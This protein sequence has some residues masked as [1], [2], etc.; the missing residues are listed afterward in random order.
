MEPAER[1]KVRVL[2]EEAEKAAAR[3]RE[4]IDE[5]VRAGID[6]SEQERAQTELEASIARMK[7]VYR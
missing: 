3:A 5:A 7:A 2:I 4:I 1:E 6:M